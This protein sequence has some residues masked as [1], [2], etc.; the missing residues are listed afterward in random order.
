M[1]QLGWRSA[2]QQLLSLLLGEDEGLH[3]EQALTGGAAA[4][5]IPCTV[6]AAPAA[7]LGLRIRSRPPLASAFLSLEPAALPSSSS[8]VC[9]PHSGGFRRRRAADLL[10]EVK[11][12]A[13]QEMPGQGGQEAG[14]QDGGA[15]EADEGAASPEDQQAAAQAAQ[16]A[17]EEVA[18][19]AAGGDAGDD[20]PVP[21]KWA[22]TE[23]LP[24]VTVKSTANQYNAIDMAD[25]DGGKSSVFRPNLGCKCGDWRPAASHP[26]L[27][28]KKGFLQAHPDFKNIVDKIKVHMEDTTE[29]PPVVH[30]DAEYDLRRFT[31]PAQLAAGQIRLAETLP[32]IP[33]SGAQVRFMTFCPKD[34]PHNYSLKVTALDTAG[35]EI[36]YFKDAESTYEAI[37]APEEPEGVDA[38][39]AGDPAAAT[40][41]ND[42]EAAAAEA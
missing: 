20:K 14:L 16:N 21:M 35:R 33:G 28:F 27:V 3:A 6:A 7:G 13:F 31:N 5:E 10:T 36:P 19:E 30:W 12:T 39:A 11:A 40:D 9:W 8:S 2:S 15:E 29:N 18:A 42:A 32:A 41:P 25:G 38:A 24:T 22:N 23:G 37:P 4:A 17:E 1:P 34:G 26:T